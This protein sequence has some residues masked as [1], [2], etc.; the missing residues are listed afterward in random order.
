MRNC[1][2]DIFVD[3]LEMVSL[4]G[5]AKWIMLMEHPIKASGKRDFGRVKV[6]ILAITTLFMVFGKKEK[7]MEMPFVELQ[8]CILKVL[9]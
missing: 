9:L 8:T 6:C 2:R 3:M 7:S 1:H 5:L 4:M